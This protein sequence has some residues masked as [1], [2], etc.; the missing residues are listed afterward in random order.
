MSSSATAVSAEEAA[1]DGSTSSPS[2]AGERQ[3]SKL[4][5]VKKTFGAWLRD[6]SRG[7][8]KT[9][10]KARPTA[11]AASSSSSI[12]R[13]LPPTPPPRDNNG[14]EAGDGRSPSPPVTLHMDELAEGFL[15]EGEEDHG[16][17]GSRPMGMDVAKSL[18]AVKNVGSE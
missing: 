1:A 6:R 13:P 18:E 4:V 7:C 8:A 15:D 9:W 10:K 17:V 12:A 5:R 14:Q 16:P 3:T 2:P 11:T